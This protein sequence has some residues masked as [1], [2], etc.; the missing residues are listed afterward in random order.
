[1]ESIQMKR[2]HELT[3]NRQTDG[4]DDLLITFRIVWTY[5]GQRK[6]V[7]QKE[8]VF[9]TNFC[10]LGDFGLLVLVTSLFCFAWVK[11]FTQNL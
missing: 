7:K 11:L 3:E 1:M 9:F 4:I 6:K 5:D 10:E 2:F 8:N